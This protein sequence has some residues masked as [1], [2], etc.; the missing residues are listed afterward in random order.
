MSGKRR[1]EL[2]PLKPP[3]L[4]DVA[5]TSYAHSALDD[6]AVGMHYIAEGYMT[7]DYNAVSKRCKDSLSGLL[8]KLQAFLY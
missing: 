6:S 5:A 2:P 1:A 8:Q 7:L 4:P 3:Q